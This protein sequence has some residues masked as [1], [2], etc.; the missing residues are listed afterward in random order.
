MKALS[1]VLLA[2]GCYGLLFVVLGSGLLAAIFSG[3]DWWAAYD[4]RGL[5]GWYV[6]LWDWLRSNAAAAGMAA[7]F[8][9]MALA[10]AWL[11]L[12]EENPGAGN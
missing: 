4:F 1:W 9:V 6:G 8:L 2:V 7:L 5:A 10:G 11:Q 3:P 12:R